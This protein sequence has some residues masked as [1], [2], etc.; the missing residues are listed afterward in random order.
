MA[1]DRIGKDGLTAQT[2]LETLPAAMKF[3]REEGALSY[4][5]H[6]RG[7]QVI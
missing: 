5:D 4:K 3:D 7:P 1:A 2:L 6:Y